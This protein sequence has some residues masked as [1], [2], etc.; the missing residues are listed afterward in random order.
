MGLPTTVHGFC[1]N[2][3]TQDSKQT[4]KTWSLFMWKPSTAV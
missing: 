2:A 4:T 3:C 1:E